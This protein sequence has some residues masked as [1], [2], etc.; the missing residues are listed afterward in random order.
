MSSS[1]TPSKLSHSLRIAI[2][3][4][5]IAIGLNFF[6]FGFAVLFNPSLGKDFRTQSLTNLYSWLAAPAATGWVHP[7]AQWAFLIIGACLILGLATRIAAIVGIAVTFLSFLPNVS[8]NA[9][10]IEQFINDEV[11]VI[12]CLLV[13]LLSDAGSYLG[14]DNFIHISFRHKQSA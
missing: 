7:F 4:L 1:R 14:V 11:I 10:S 3:L 12:I 5:R 6:F 9:L 8:Y 13:I 2:L